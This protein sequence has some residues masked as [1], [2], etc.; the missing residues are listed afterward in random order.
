MRSLI[1]THIRPS[2]WWRRATWRLDRDL[3]IIGRVVPAGFITD[4]ISTPWIMAWLVSPTG[5]GMPASVLH[6][7]LL[8]LLDGSQSRRGA[9]AMFRDALLACGVSSLR[10][11]LMFYAVRIYA[12]LKGAY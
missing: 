4:G 5:I 11:R 6:D 12:F 9:D 3:R 1:V 10:A 8:S 7:Y 2:K